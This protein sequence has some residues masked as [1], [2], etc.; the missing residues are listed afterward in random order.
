MNQA[1]RETEPDLGTALQ[2]LEHIVFQMERNKLSV[3]ESVSQ[4]EKGI[5]LV[6]QCQQILK[7]AEQKVSVLL[8]KGGKTLLHPYQLNDQSDDQS[9]NTGGTIEE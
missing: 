5:V 1:S 6:K 9:N 4:F 7:T 8:E 2:A 3:E